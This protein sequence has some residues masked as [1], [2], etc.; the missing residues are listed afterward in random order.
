LGNSLGALVLAVLVA[1]GVGPI[2]QNSGALLIAVQLAGAVYLVYLGVQAWRNRNAQDGPELTSVVGKSPGVLVREGFAV[3]VLNPKTAVF[4][5]TV[6]PRFLDQ[7]ASTSVQLLSMGSVFVLIAF[8]SDS[9]Y[10]LLAG[11]VRATFHSH[12]YALARLG[13]VGGVLITGLGGV[14]AVGTI[15]EMLR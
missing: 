4:F 11:Q 5:A 10:G 15:L 14:L 7:S 6:M 3:G 1:A 12:P 13:A 9:S 2:V 8:M